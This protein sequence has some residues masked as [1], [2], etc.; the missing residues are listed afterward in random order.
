MQVMGGVSS[1][2]HTKHQSQ[3][4]VLGNVCL[5]INTLAS[6]VYYL[7]AKRLV[8]ASPVHHA[9]ASWQY[10]PF[11]SYCSACCI[12]WKYAAHC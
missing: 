8:Q 10:P 12:C 4:M 6:A 7:G 1:A 5:L 2:G 9:S 3:T 11:T